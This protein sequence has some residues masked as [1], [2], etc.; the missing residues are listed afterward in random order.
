MKNIP[1]LSRLARRFQKGNA[2]LKEIVRFYQLSIKLPRLRDCL[3]E[4]CDDCQN[5]AHASLVKTGFL[6]IID[7]YVE[8]LARFQ[9][10]VET[11]VDLEAADQHEYIIKPDFDDKLK[12]LVSS[13]VPPVFFSATER[14]QN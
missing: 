2:G 1:D 10:L 14:S 5:A 7:K 6:D 9:E 4:F 11:T 3:Q 12:G 13:S 8:E